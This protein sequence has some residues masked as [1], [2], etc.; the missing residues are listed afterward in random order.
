[1][2]LDQDAVEGGLLGR[3]R[4]EHLATA[5]VT[6]VT[7]DER[8]GEDLE[9]PRLAVGVALE[10]VPEAVGAQHGLL[11]LILGVAGV[12]REPIGGAIEGPHVGH[13]DRLELLAL[14]AISAHSTDL[15]G[16]ANRVFP[17]P[18]PGP[19]R[20]LWRLQG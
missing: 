1:A 14:L 13:G 6:L 9:Q 20:I 18:G 8:V 2:L 3:R 12:A 7:A 10:A 15:T 4:A 16:A 17:G 19:S 11:D 5:P